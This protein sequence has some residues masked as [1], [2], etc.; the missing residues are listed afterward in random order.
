MKRFIF[1]ALLI[2][3]SA[4]EFNYYDPVY[5]DRDRIVGRYEMEEYSETYNDLTNY[6]LWIE[7][8]NRS[9]GA[10]WIDNFYAVNIRVRATY[11]YDR[12]TIPWQTV[13]GFE[14]EG[15]GTVYGSRIVFTYRVE[16][17]YSNS[18]ADYLDATAYRDY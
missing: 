13:N 14:V 15:T 12:I 4:C 10:I 5:D 3:L 8:S 1:F 11:S 17:L 6:T 2:G 7:H 9:A 16:D 18:R